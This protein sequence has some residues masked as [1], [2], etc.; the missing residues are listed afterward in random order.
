MADT[1]VRDGAHSDQLWYT[2]DDRGAC[3]VLRVGG[4]ID[5]QN[6]PGV[7]DA[8][9]VGSGFSTGLVIDLGRA[10]IAHAE[11][12]GQLVR[13]LN[14]SHRHG[15]LMSVVDPPE[16]VGWLLSVS[17]QAAG[18]PVCASVP[19]AVATLRRGMRMPP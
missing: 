11:A 1:F 6:C 8:V 18:I 5:S 9:S 12:A 2:V 4:R 13:S 14:E 7:C 3:A 15:A 10:E 16:P 17:A 19:E